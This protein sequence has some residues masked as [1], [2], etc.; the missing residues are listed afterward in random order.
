M[1]HYNM[2]F[3]PDEY[4]TMDS[5]HDYPEPTTTS[6][7]ASSKLS[8]KPSGCFTFVDFCPQYRRKPDAW[9]FQAD[10]ETFRFVFTIISNNNKLHF[11]VDFISLDHYISLLSYKVLYFYYKNILSF[12]N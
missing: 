5:L 9:F 4:D 3:S 12:E 6:S 2:A 7:L 8:Q 11:N 1:A 10:Y